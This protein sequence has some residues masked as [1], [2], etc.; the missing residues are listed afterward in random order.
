MVSGR[1]EERR[2]V[3]TESFIEV[4]IDLIL[5]GSKGVWVWMLARPLMR[6]EGVK[7]VLDGLFGQIE[8]VWAGVGKEGL[9]G[10]RVG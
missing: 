6:S 8:L 7:E 4:A 5:D 9:L 2:D 10:A 1:R 3:P